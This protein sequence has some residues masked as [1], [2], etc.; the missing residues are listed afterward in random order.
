MARAKR[1]PRART[2]ARQVRR[3]DEK[4]ARDRSKLLD[5]EAGGRPE[6]PIDVSTPALVEPKARAVRCPRCDE[7]FD[8]ESHEAHT[9]AQPLR[10]A[11]LRCRFCGT[12]R[13]LWFRVV[14]PS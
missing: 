12:T 9:D 3:F 14:A 4:L 10:E 8:V 13:S 11:V 5:L 6:R 7:P 1:P 2:A